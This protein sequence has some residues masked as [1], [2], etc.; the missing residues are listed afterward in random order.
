MTFTISEA[1][2]NFILGDVTVSGGSLSDFSATSTT[3]YTA[4]FTPTSDGDT[5]I[6]V[7]AGGFTDAYGNNNSAASQF[8]WTYDG[9]GPTMVVTSATVSDG[10][11]SNDSSIALTFT[12]SEATTNFVESDI[13]VS[14]GSLSN[15]AASSSTV[16]TA[17]F[18]PSSDGATTIDVSAGT[19]T[20]AYGNNSSAASQ[21]N[22]TYDSV[23]PT[24]TIT[25]STVNDGDTSNYVS[26][27]LTFTLSESSTYFV[28]GDISLCGGTLSNFVG[29]GTTYTDRFKPS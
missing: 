11:T 26:I 29:S 21:F 1:T 14:G 9:T 15:F 24:I 8:S 3:V 18:T 10:A 13:T 16:Y 27:V 22:W 19:Y 2:T 20:D 4:T 23:A 28:A 17:T 7:G 25:S 12:S 5:T 6:D